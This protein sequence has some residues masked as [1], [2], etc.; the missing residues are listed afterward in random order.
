MLD[1]K[2]IRENQDTLK[3]SLKDRGV[4]IDLEGLIEVDESRRQ[5][6]V[7]LEELRQKKNIAND[8]ISRLLKDKKDARAKIASMKSTS[9]QV[10]E[11]E[12]K[13]RE[14]QGKLNDLLLVIPNIAHSSIPVGDASAQKIVRSWGE[15]KKFDFTPLNHTEIAEALDII[16]LP[17]AAKIAG[18]N[19]V[20]YKGWGARL[21]RALINFMLDLHTS[22]H[23]YT[24]IFPPF[25][26]NRR[27]MIGTG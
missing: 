15:V 2:F 8:E 1:I 25:L 18:S 11:L 3:K 6:L 22:K 5:T 13:L 24:E 19:F 26:V 10:D 12:A 9:G 14:Y 17:R 16:D 20:L 21:E 7:K 4:K 27:A 23:G